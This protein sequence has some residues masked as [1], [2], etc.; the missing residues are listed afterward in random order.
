MEFVYA[1][2]RELE[3]FDIDGGHSTQLVLLFENLLRFFFV[4]RIYLECVFNRLVGGDSKC[5][6]V[7]LRFED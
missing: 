3:A 4:G 2:D 5:C 1:D 6:H 7:A